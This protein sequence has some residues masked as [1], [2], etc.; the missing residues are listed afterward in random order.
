MLGLKDLFQSQLQHRKDVTSMYSH[1][2][3]LLLSIV[4]SSDPRCLSQEL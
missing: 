3:D 2:A 1:V 4:I